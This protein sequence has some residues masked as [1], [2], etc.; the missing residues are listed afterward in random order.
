MKL[1]L[2][3]ASPRRC[4]LLRAIDLDFGVRPIDLDEVAAAGDRLPADAAVTVAVAKARAADGAAAVVLAADTIVVLDDRTLGKPVDDE[5][6]RRML[7]ALRGRTHVVVTGVAVR[8]EDSEWTAA[9]ESEVRMRAY[10]DAEIAAY[11]ATG[12]GRDKAG[13]YGIQD[14]PFVPVEAI[15]GCYCNVMGLP[16]WTAYRLLREAGCVAPRRPGEVLSRCAV[17]P[18]NG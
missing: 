11:V 3:S 13:S 14:E 8:T 9:V 6:A 4:E 18:M 1:L 2:A 12:G 5:D 7:A 15:H 10:S 17:C 16:L